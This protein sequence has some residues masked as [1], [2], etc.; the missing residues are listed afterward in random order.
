M[1]W[2]RP[3]LGGLVVTMERIGDGTGTPRNT[4]YRPT[5]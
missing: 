5:S 1:I 4:F 2:T 3:D